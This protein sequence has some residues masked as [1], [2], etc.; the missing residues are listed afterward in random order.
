MTESFGDVSSGPCLM[1]LS[2]YAAIVNL[3]FSSSSSS[4]VIRSSVSLVLA[5]ERANKRGPALNPTK[6][7]TYVEGGEECDNLPN[8]SRCGRAFVF[9]FSLT[10]FPYVSSCFSSYNNKKTVMVDA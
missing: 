5:I 3:R 9:Y 7:Q 4:M 10:S 2:S 8:G 6:V 1:S